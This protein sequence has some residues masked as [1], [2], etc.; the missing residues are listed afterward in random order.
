MNNNMFYTLL[1]YRLSHLP[2]KEQV[3]F[4]FVFEQIF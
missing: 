2:I 4:A 1:D 3:V